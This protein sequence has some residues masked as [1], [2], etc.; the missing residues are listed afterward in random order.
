MAHEPQPI[1]DGQHGLEGRH[2]G[3]R[4]A[5]GQAGEE[6]GVGQ[7]AQPWRAPKVRWARVARLPGRS[8]AGGVGAMAVSASLGEERRT[9]SS[10]RLRVGGQGPGKDGPGPPRIGGRRADVLAAVQG[11]EGPDRDNK[12]APRQG[13]PLTDWGRAND[14]PRAKRFPSVVAN[15]GRSIFMSIR[16]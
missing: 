10:D 1:I 5:V 8:V 14:S 7:T 11:R 3:V 15:V 12:G 9:V 6:L 13:G 4:L 16:S 2:A